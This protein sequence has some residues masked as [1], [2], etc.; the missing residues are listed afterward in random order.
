MREVHFIHSFVNCTYGIKFKNPLRNPRLWRFTPKVCSASFIVLALMLSL[1]IDFELILIDGVKLK[2][3]FIFY[4]FAIIIAPVIIFLNNWMILEFL[5]FYMNLR[6]G[7]SIF[8]R[9]ED[10]K[11]LN[12]CSL[13]AFGKWW[14]VHNSTMSCQFTSLDAI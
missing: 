11:S 3:D 9:K 8:E 10:H 4:N 14:F 2:S 1:L 6:I 5:K 7:F 12:T 13:C